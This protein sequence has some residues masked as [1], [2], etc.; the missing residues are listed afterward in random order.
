M[1][2][3]TRATHPTGDRRRHRTGRLPLLL[4]L[5]GLAAPVAA[6]DVMLEKATNGQDADSAPG[7]VVVI[8][9]PVTWTYEV[10]AG[11]RDLVNVVVTDD[12]G[13]T[14]SCPSSTLGSGESMT[15]SA[16]GV[17]V[18]GQYANLGT[19][20]A[21][22]AITGQPVTASDPSHYFGLAELALTIDKATNGFD[23]D[24]PPGP[25]LPV[26]STVD[27][28]YEVT[29][30]GSTDTIDNIAVTDNQGVVVSCPET[31]LAPGA[32]MTCTG[33]GVAQVGQ[34]SNLGTATGELPGPIPLVANDP[35]HYRGQRLVLQKRTNGV[36]ADSPPGPVIP[37]GDPVN[38][39]YVVSNPGPQ[40]VSNI[41][42]TDDQGVTV[43][44]PQDTLAAGENMTC[45]GSGVAVAG[46]YANLGT[47]DGELPGGAPLSASDPSHYLGFL[48]DAILLEKSTNGQD[49]DT[50]P[51]PVLAVGA[52][53]NWTYE[54]VNP[55]LDTI[56]NIVVTDDQGVTVTCPGTTLAGGESM[57][58]TAS[59][60]AV[61]GSYENLGT[62]DGE[63]PGSQAASASDFSHYYGQDMILDW[64]DAPA[65]YPTGLAA[66]GANHL[67][68]SVVY[69]GACVDSELDGQPSAAADG[70][71]L[72][73]GATTSGTCAVT[74]DDEDGVTFLDP[75]VAGGTV[76]IEV[77]ASAP[78]TLTAFVDFNVDGDWTDPTDVLFPLGAPLTSGVNA[79]TFSVPADAV[80]GT[81]F[82]RFRCTTDTPPEGGAFGPQGAAADGEVEDYAVVIEL[83][84]EATLVDAPGTP[85]MPGDTISYRADIT[86]LAGTAKGLTLDVPIDPN[87]TLVGGVTTTPLA[88]DDG[89]YQGDP[90]APT[91]VDGLVQPR[92][93]DNDFGIPAPA[94]VAVV[95]QATTLGGSVDIAADGSFTYTPPPGALGGEIDTFTYDL[96]NGIPPS[97]PVTDMAT[98]TIVLGGAPQARDDESSGLPAYFVAAGGTLVVPD[99]P[100]DP[101]ERNDSPG[102]PPATLTHF[103]GADLGGAVTDHTAGT[104]VTP[105]PGYADGSLTVVGN[106][107]VTFVAPTGLV[108][109]WRF[110]YRLSNPNGT[111]D[112][113]VTIEVQVPPDA[114]DDGPDPGSVPGDPF[115]TDAGVPIDTTTHATPSVLANDVLGVPA[116]A[117][118]SYGTSSSPGDEPAEGAPT[119]TDQG[120]TVQVLTNGDF[121]YVPPAPPAPLGAAPAGS[122]SF[123]GLD[124]FGY[125]LAN[126]AGSDAAVVTIAVGAPAACADDTYTATFN[127]GIG[128]SAA[129]GVILGAGTDSGTDISVTNVQGSGANV[130]SPTATDDGGSVSLNADGSFT[131]DPP[132]ADA[133][134]TFTYTVGNAFGD[135]SACTVTVD[136]S[137]STV[138]FIDNT[139]SGASDGT[140]EN[141]F[142]SIA[143]FDAAAGPANGDLVYLFAGSGY[144]EA[145]GID[146]LDSQQ[147]YGQVVDLGP[148]VTEDPASRNFPPPT[149]ATPQL[150]ATAGD[151][152]EV[153]A[154]NTVRGLD[155]GDTAAGFGL[156]NRAAASV[157]S[158]TVTDVEI[159][160]AGGA[161]SIDS[162]GNLDNAIFDVLSSSSSPGSSLRLNAAGTP[163]ITSGGAGFGGSA[164]SS[165]AVHIS[166]T[167]SLTY[168]GAVT[169]GNAGSLVSITSHTTGTVLFS[170]ALGATGGDGIQANNADGTYFFSGAVT[171]NG[172]DAGVDILGGSAGSF[173]FSNAG[174]SITGPTT[175]PSFNVASSS[176]TVSYAGTITQPNAQTAVAF[177]GNAGGTATFSGAI[178][179]DTTTANAIDLANPGTVTLSGG[180]DVDTTTGLGLRAMSGGTINV[181]GTNSVTTTTGTAVSIAS[182]IGGSGVTLAAVTSTASGSNPAILLANTGAG[183]FT[184]NG[185]TLSNKTADAVTLDNTGGAVTFNNVTIEDIGTM[186]GPFDTRSQH[187]GIHGQNVG[188]G[189]VLN[190]VTIRR[191]SDMAVNGALFSDGVSPT[192]WT[193]LQIINSTLQDSNRFHIAG[194]ADSINEGMVRIVGLRGNVSIT[195]SVFERGAELLDLFVTAGTLTMVVTEN[196][197]SYAYKEFTS[198][199]LASVG[200]MC[201]D[202]TVQGA[203]TA[204][205]TIGDEVGTV[206]GHQS[207][208][209][210]GNAFLNCRVGSVRIGNDS[211]AT[212][213]INAI[214]G[215]NTF[216]VD[217]HSSGFGGD[218]DFPMGGVQY[219]TRGEDSG[220]LDGIITRNYFDE[221]TNAA[222]GVGQVTLDLEDGSHQVR[223]DHNTFD[224]PGNAPW[225]VRADS[226]VSAR[227]LLDSNT[228]IQGFFNCPDPSCGGGYFGPGL[229][230]L[231]Q[232]Q[233]AA[234]L[235]LTIQNEAFAPHDVGF[236]PGNTTEMHALNAG[237]GSSVCL[238]LA[239]NTSPHGYGLREE[240]GTLVLQGSSTT[241]SGSCASEGGSTPNTA[242]PADP[243]PATC[244]TVADENGNT[245]GAG[246]AAND[247]PDVDVIFGT[248]D[249]TATACLQPAGG[250]F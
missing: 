184:V 18:S 141:P 46:P 65:P 113:T 5:A 210:D 180:F 199:P 207:G 93:L 59:D 219:I 200:T 16:S 153:G 40:T 55:G 36:D 15:C 49:A 193:G 94:V 88:I 77:V 232:A 239:N 14:V 1:A 42:V 108:G 192:S 52:P 155:I 218:F 102:N 194:V 91:T 126:S 109:P 157:G 38:W 72:G 174:S 137:G 233:N 19:V 166:G 172:G 134:D 133:Q 182:T 86:S 8:G 107:A 124:A 112:A 34:Y 28:T 223:V 69:L 106:G 164:A 118:I 140:L 12:Q 87:M 236:D 202:V 127:I 167:V 145:D 82:A 76:D 74:D 191:I 152:V 227:V 62:A 171:L 229:R 179:A 242:P 183:A 9:S 150:A 142:Q 188:G 189:L 6:Q 4:L 158:L 20:D 217:D 114:I 60:V 44:C 43:T 73:A 138:W 215:N 177:S 2:R 159:T 173:T 48:P 111:S 211:G 213:H 64:G 67:L 122:G 25:T 169:K 120:G 89:V 99:G 84:I 130:G 70:D 143:A 230:S 22:F 10:T 224:T 117:V 246:N 45:T 196:Q 68:P 163:T 71:D 144:N 205:V 79:L 121:V 231:A 37:V 147:L 204:D 198:G 115:H 206:T 96:E 214:V 238:H 41:G 168:P 11:S 197:F 146:L 32:S 222:G 178:D 92:L 216:V 249:I 57:T 24:S 235:D 135:S 105:L 17:A 30:V 212:G 181:T 165:A 23:A 156:R 33:S 110:E 245:G 56:T 228:Y 75:L 29:N 160:G 101:V 66:N 35:S 80:G 185:G 240:A 51:G 201:I 203:A 63:L 221:I 125:A 139:A 116:G 148:L 53:V 237:G 161:V 83:D 13:V 226:A 175:G 81:T 187:D 244:I 154:N 123:V 90:V 132:P 186:T 247:P 136:M 3:S 248:I 190:G 78:C 209:D 104:T 103:G 151:G 170:G 195:G 225:F 234:D 39:T 220:G 85:A 47:A 58:C 243:N 119:P 208:E 250:I 50:P 54:V 98:A 176:A 149:G 241:T 21:E 7:P 100:S 95:G 26:G 27:W 31:S 128:H 131:Y 162:G 61:A 129:S 97:A